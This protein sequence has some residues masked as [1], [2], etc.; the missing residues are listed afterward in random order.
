MLN[1]PFAYFYWDPSPEIFHFNLP[2]LGRP[3]LWY[4][5]FFAVGFL[6]GYWVLLKVL[7][8]DEGL[9]SKAKFLAEKLTFYVVVGT[10]IGA[11]IGD[12]LFYHRWA[13][14]IR[15]PL[16]V[17]K[18]WEG[19][20]ASHGGVIGIM[21]A[22]IL[23]QRKYRLFSWVRLLDLLAVPSGLVGCFIRLGN[24]I[25]Q[26]ILGKETHVPWAVVFGHPA[27]QSMPAPR[28]PVQLYEAAFY[29][30]VFFLIF[31]LRKEKKE[32]YLS[33]L[34][35]VLVFGFRFAVEF[36]KEEQSTFMGAHPML[37]MGQILSLP[38]ILFGLFL[39]LRKK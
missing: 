10:V 4:G 32:G 20:L 19:G 1:K 7:R 26:E 27:N 23:F 6:L 5:F 2:L 25:N 12:V 38:F 39:L 13:E 28:H 14:F 15:D 24:F 31:F 17:I 16:V 22:V 18:F 35:F 8:E 34:F 36:L 29:L 21:V 11:R 30:L 9:R 37:D 33:G 3:L